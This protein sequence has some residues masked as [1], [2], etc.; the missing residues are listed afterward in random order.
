MCSAF[1]QQCPCDSLQQVPV[2]LKHGNRMHASCSSRPEV[3]QQAGAQGRRDA[4]FQL[5]VNLL[6]QQA[7]PVRAAEKRGIGRYIKK[8]ALDPLVT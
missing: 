4:L 3:A 1:Y 5:T 2:T 7:L 8:K 6:L